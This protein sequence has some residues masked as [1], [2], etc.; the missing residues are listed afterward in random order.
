[1]QV[2]RANGWTVDTTALTIRETPDAPAHKLPEVSLHALI[3]FGLGYLE[4]Q[5]AARTVID[6]FKRAWVG[7]A[8]GRKM[9]DVS[10]D[11]VP[12]S[13]SEAYRTALAKAHSD[14]FAKLLE[15]YK[16][17]AREGGLDPVAK[18][19][20]KLGRR[21]LQ[22]FATSRGWFVLPEGKRQV[23]RDEDP[24]ADPKGR[25]ATFG[26]ALDAFVVS[27]G[28]APQLVDPQTK[29][30]VLFKVRSGET[31]AA[32]LRREAE[33]IVKERGDGEKYNVVVE[34]GGEF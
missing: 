17:G 20:Y 26:D 8:E 23:A 24:Y 29:K 16:V 32:V 14:I 3:H 5:S 12:D 10:K 22:L 4:S 30:P 19:V 28:P 27:Q 15:G 1:M 33:R 34:G 25:Y 6:G 31:I 9:S 2:T 21:Y 11:A 7:A 18:E 13:E